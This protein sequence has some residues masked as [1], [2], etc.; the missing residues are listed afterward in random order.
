MTQDVLA[1]LHYA[2]STL[3]EREAAIL[4]G[5]FRDGCSPEELAAAFA[6]TADEIH[7]AQVKALRKLRQP[8]RWN[9]IC[10]GIAGY[11]KSRAVA[12]YNK[13]YSKGY[14]V[15]LQ[16]GKA[17]PERA[18]P[19]PCGSEEVLAQ[20]V[21][22]LNLS[23]RSQ[24]CLADLRCETLGDMVHLTESQIMRTRNLGKISADEIARKLNAAGVKGSV[25]DQFLR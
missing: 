14:M 15:G 24:Q 19:L 21:Q 12:E 6:I 13:G 23:A 1:G 8:C 17:D 25:W 11:C 5:Y 3:E 20:P 22:F 18:V 7:Q 2:L 10:L 16:H 9:Y 4:T